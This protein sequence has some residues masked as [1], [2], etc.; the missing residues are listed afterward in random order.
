M[1]AKTATSTAVEESTTSAARE[2]LDTAGENEITQ[3]D[4]ISLSSIQKLFDLEKDYISK[5][6]N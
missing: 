6:L 3:I 2:G 4:D 1:N 5:E